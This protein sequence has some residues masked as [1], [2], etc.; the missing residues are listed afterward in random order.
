M[1]FCSMHYEHKGKIERNEQDIQRIWRE[2]NM[3]KFWLIGIMG[4]LV[5]NLIVLV[6]K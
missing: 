3:F 2:M 6:L 4:G 5:T 1:D